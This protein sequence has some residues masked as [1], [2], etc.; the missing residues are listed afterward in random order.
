MRKNIPS[1]L[2]SEMPV[3]SVC[4]AV[5]LSAKTAR[6]RASEIFAKQ[7]YRFTPDVSVA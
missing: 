6:N 3:I 4:V 1:T 7:K 2:R 5:R